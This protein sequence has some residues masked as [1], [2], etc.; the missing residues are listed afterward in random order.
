MGSAGGTGIILDEI[1]LRVQ[2]TGLTNRATV[3]RNS[4]YNRRLSC[5]RSAEERPAGGQVH[6][7]LLRGGARLRVRLRLQHHRGEG[8]DHGERWSGFLAL[9]KD[10]DPEVIGI[11]LKIRTYPN[12]WEWI[13]LPM[14]SNL[15]KIKPLVRNFVLLDQD[16]E[17]YV[18]PADPE[19]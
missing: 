8:D 11:Q 2:Y 16:H 19:S 3:K 18:D 4:S 10:P 9:V 15:D 6:L 12:D 5:R 17:N 13:I 7:L 1:S 14:V